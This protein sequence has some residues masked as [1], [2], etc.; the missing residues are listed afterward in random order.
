[1]NQR[2]LRSLYDFASIYLLTWQKKPGGVKEARKEAWYRYGRGGGEIRRISSTVS[3][4][5]FRARENR[6]KPAV[7]G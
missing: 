5:Q 6:E 2:L 7:A 3:L 1:M 4:G